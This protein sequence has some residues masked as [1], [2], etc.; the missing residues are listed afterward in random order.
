MNTS[1]VSGKS[2]EE[3]ARGVNAALEQLATSISR[4][5]KKL[6]EITG[7]GK[8]GNDNGIR[9]VQQKGQYIIEAKFKDGWARLPLPFELI[10]K[11]DS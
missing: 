10:S 7:S 6:S 3:I 5:D 9:L 2:V 8:Q 4:I 11:K 1:K